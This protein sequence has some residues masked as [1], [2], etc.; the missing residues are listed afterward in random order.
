VEVLLF[1]ST[2]Q[3]NRRW[4][5]SLLLHRFNDVSILVGSIYNPDRLHFDK[6]NFDKV[7]FLELLALASLDYDH[8]IVLGDFNIEILS[9][10]GCPTFRMFCAILDSLSISYFPVPRSLFLARVSP[11]F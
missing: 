10:P 5:K 2:S 3:L 1:M 6:V 11:T 8:L 9:D 4:F 7:K